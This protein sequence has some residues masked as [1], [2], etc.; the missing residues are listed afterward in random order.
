MSIASKRTLAVVAFLC[1]SLVIAIAFASEAY[2]P[3]FAEHPYLEVLK[4]PI[5]TLLLF[6]FFLSLYLYH[7]WYVKGEVAS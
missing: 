1:G 3:V 7:L 4:G 2:G 5:V 6:G